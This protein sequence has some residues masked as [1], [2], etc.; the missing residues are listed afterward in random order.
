MFLHVCY[1]LVVERGHPLVT[2]LT[3]SCV[4]LT[5]HFAHNWSGVRSRSSGD[6]ER[7]HNSLIPLA[8]ICGSKLNS[9]LH[10]LVGDFSMLITHQ[11]LLGRLNQP[12]MQLVQETKPSPYL[13]AKEC[14]GALLL[15]L[16]RLLKL[17]I[18]SRVR[19]CQDV[20]L[21]WFSNGMTQ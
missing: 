18:F 2:C 5:I 13:F 19:I 8:E 11:Q 1:I 14:R 12:W 7:Q 3:L 17:S 9:I 16:V 15:M 6:W 20:P 21:R 10:I 4:L